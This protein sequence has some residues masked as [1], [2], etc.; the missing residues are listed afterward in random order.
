M[1]YETHYPQKGYQKVW[2]ISLWCPICE[3]NGIIREGAHK[4]L[5]VP[6]RGMQGGER[7]VYYVCISCHTQYRNLTCYTLQE[8]KEHHKCHL[9]YVNHLNTLDRAEQ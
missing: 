5:Y 7:R 1:L 6:K 2:P 8:T 4:P 9:D 3:K